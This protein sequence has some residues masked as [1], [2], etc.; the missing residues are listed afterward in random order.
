MEKNNKGKLA[1]GKIKNLKIQ[2]RASEVLQQKV[3]SSF[4]AR[5]KERRENGSCKKFTAG[6]G[7]P[8]TGMTS[9]REGSPLEHRKADPGSLCSAFG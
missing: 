9:I 7:R 4:W 5:G 6:E 1:E 3:N 8:E 2:A